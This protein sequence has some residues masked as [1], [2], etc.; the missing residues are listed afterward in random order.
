[1]RPPEPR[2]P[3]G[4]L[5]PLLERRAEVA[6][7]QALVDCACDGDGRF[8][9]LEGG[10]GIGKTRLLDEGRGIA[11]SAG[12]L[13]LSARAGELEG[14]FPYGIVRQ[15]F[16]P[17][18]AAPGS[19]LH[20]ELFAG[21]AAL[22]EPLFGVSQMR[23]ADEAASDGSF[24]VL[25][26]LYWF[27]VNVCT[28]Q[29]TLLAID[30]LHWAD[31]PSLRWLN[32]LTRRLEGL[33]LLV[34]V[35]TRSPEAEGRDRALVAELIDDPRAVAI[36]PKTLGRA[37][38]A[39]LA[40]DVYGLHP[41]DA[42]CSGLQ[43]ATRGN[44]LYV[45]A[46]LD[47]VAREGMRGASEEVPRLLEIG[48]RG[49][50]RGVG[51]RLARLAPQALALLQAAA[52]LG[53]GTELNRAAA[54]AGTPRTELGAAATA[55]VGL[56]LLRQDDPLEFVHPIVRHVVYESLDVVE[57]ARVHRR[58]AELL[59]NWGARPESAAAH[60][61][62]TPGGEDAFLVSTLRRAADRALAHGAPDVAVSYLARALEERSDSATREEILV[63]LGLVERLTDV[64]AAAEHLREGLE[65]V[66]EPAKKGA[67]ALE[68]GRA[69]FYSGRL[70]ETLAV[71]EK[72]LNEVDREA[73]PDLHERL[74][75]ELI[76]AAWWE[77][78]SYPLARDRIAEIDLES[79]H[80]GFGSELLFAMVSLYECR[81]GSNRER[82]VELAR[83]ALASGNLRASGSAGF[84]CAAQAFA[85]AGLF[86]EALSV[87]SDAL[88]AARRCGDILQVAMTVMTRGTIHLRRGD[89]PMA[90]AD[91]REASDLSA[92]HGVHVARPYLIGFLA[93]ALL[94]H[95]DASEAEHIIEEAGFADQPPASIH[96]AW[97][98][99]ARGRARIETGR[100][101][102]GVEDLLQIGELVRLVPYDLPSSIPWRSWAAEGLRLLDRDDEAQAL[103][104]KELELAQRWGAPQAI[105]VALRVLGL[106]KG[107][108]E[109]E[110]LL[111]E[112]VSTLADSGARAD[113][114]RALIDL[115]AALRR[116]NKRSE[117]R[118]RLR[119]GVDL[120]HGIGALGLVERGNAELAATGAKPRKVLQTGLAALTASERRVAQLAARGVSNK[121]IA[122]SLF[123]TVK[124]VEVH[125]SSV[126]RKLEIS[127]RTQLDEAFLAAAA[128]LAGS[129]STSPGVV[130]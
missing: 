102:R 21:A 67:V 93:H 64:S 25:Y 89:I 84:A 120:A 40:R 57:R 9:V 77:A 18:L 85:V 82:A 62:Q 11:D 87:Y 14:E 44:P 115:G 66:S 33:P 51:L 48:A 106:M 42:F 22:G 17:L 95:G 114:A 111:R 31:T 129:S 16:E 61:L 75:A 86:Q 65:L 39:V 69:L 72:A 118:E 71:W 24:A 49:V 2:V 29:R 63:E 113:E 52:I 43:A 7:M 76:N 54:L 121:A 101:E 99:L 92:A 80:G 130:I 19:E 37:S 125:L 97:L 119:D 41:T 58:A 96:L 10:V 103:V 73:E 100:P 74:L 55:L 98:A 123:I 45:G 46:V 78:E 6:E 128:P 4:T 59:V 124:T 8:V 91:L 81:L 83:R 110:R 53:D 30:D 79:L 5:T 117:A 36:R 109:G 104:E 20:S 3:W 126:Y 122:Q 26:G 105:G 88:S 28:R 90:L 112:A 12:M 32:Y 15:L 27:T 50:A 68:L 60:L 13:V 127:S 70:A 38:I 56:E 35:T 1:M 94:E 47:V 34:M 108:E 116:A 107:S 23:G